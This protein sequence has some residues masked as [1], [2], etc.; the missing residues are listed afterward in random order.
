[1][2]DLILGAQKA[3]KL[4]WARYFTQEKVGRR[5][6]VKGKARRGLELPCKSKAPG[7][8]QRTL[9]L[10]GGKSGK[11]VPGPGR[12]SEGRCETLGQKREGGSAKGSRTLT[13]EMG[14]NQTM[15]TTTRRSE[16]SEKGGGNGLA[17]RKG[18]ADKNARPSRYWGD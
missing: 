9:G 2:G 11:F 6:S 15:S 1:L 12:K 16:R 17:S 18:W 10:I 5:S 14:R 7:N 4:Q 3:D 8:Q 13:F